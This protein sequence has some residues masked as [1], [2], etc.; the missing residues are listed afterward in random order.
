[1]NNDTNIF[2]TP[3]IKMISFNNSEIKYLIISVSK[4][5]DLFQKGI[6]SILKNSAEMERLQ[7][8]IRFLANGKQIS[9]E[10]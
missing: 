5:L 1:M 3:L 8:S 10:Y 2:Y 9:V 7:I 6:I 4:I